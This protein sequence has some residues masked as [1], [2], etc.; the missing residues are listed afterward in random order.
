M[1]NTERT[2]DLYGT[3]LHREGEV[4]SWQAEVW[5]T[6]FDA[7]LR[8]GVRKPGPMITLFG[9]FTVA[10]NRIRQFA[11]SVQSGVPIIGNVSAP[12]VGAIVSTFK[13][14]E[15]MVTLSPEEYQT[16][17]ALVTTGHRLRVS[18]KFVKPVGG[19][20]KILAITVS[21][22]TQGISSSPKA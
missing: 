13:V 19:S 5:V 18:C 11:V 6:T 3:I 16:I 12:A 4:N 17:L 15:A 2:D 9:T 20:A 10:V 22:A 21:T 8:D 14:V 1:Q 7:N